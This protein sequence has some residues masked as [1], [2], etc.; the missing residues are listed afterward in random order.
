MQ[1]I[2]EVDNF[3]AV[4]LGF[5]VFLLG[6]KLNQLV[7]ALNRFSIPEP[8]TGGLLASISV[9]MFYYVTGTEL[10]FALEAR[11]FLLVVFFAS[12]GL[13]A[14]LSDLISGGKLLVLLLLLTF[15]AIVVQNAVG[16]GG[17]LMFGL[18]AQSGVLFGSASLIGGHGTAIAWS[19][20]VGDVTG[21]V[22]APEL[23][24][25]MATLGLVVAALVGGPMAKYLIERNRLEPENPDENLTVGIAEDEEHPNTMIN[26]TSI[27][28][29]MLWL[30]I[31][32][33]LG[34]GLHGV[35]QHMGLKL[36]M[37]VPCLI[38][39]IILA[40]LRSWLTPNAQPIA[41]T[42]SLALIS[43]FS[44]GTFLAM[45]LMALQ[46][47][48]LADVGIAIFVILAVQVF[49]TVAVVMFGLFVVMGR[50]YLAAV[51]SAG[52]AGFA[53]GATPT[54]IA[55]MTAVTKQ[56]GPA[57][58]AFVVLPLVSAFFVD[59]ANAVVIQMIVNF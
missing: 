3:F 17:A 53:L 35:I 51:L 13:N 30:N 56:Y 57:P 43:D 44:L 31:A 50:D 36:P 38:M 52:F 11:D 34:V 26:H 40:N 46:L 21:M 39:G 10:K 6:Y 27:M 49:T 24:V 37:F 20:N 45:S 55:N 2:V 14:R 48:T 19:P 33:A 12:I 59:L 1:P 29:V 58:I 42:R 28:R 5:A 18:P 7:P 41:R 47:W 22:G 4:N 8:V 32:I 16:V 25:A 15:V 23:G 54:A 9:G